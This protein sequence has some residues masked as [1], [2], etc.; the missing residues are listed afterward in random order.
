MDLEHSLRLPP[1]F[2]GMGLE[3]FGSETKGGAGKKFLKWEGSIQKGVPLLKGEA[4][5]S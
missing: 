5:E 4:G 2:K 3:N 1:L